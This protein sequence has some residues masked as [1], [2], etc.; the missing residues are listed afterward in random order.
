M[1]QQCAAN[2][3]L[4]GTRIDVILIRPSIP[5]G[6][7]PFAHLFS[8]LVLWSLLFRNDF[9]SL[10]SWKQRWMALVREVHSSL[11]SIG[12]I[13]YK[14]LYCLLSGP[15]V[16][17]LLLSTDCVVKY[18]ILVLVNSSLSTIFHPFPFV[19][20]RN[21][22]HWIRKAKHNVVNC[23]YVTQASTVI[24]EPQLGFK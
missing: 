23:L 16:R 1:M 17:Y 15:F 22:S 6:W 5:N 11:P 20:H 3:C 10:L 18:T 4:R 12:Y 13:L 14:H 9:D 24:F 21:S 2:Y 19:N 8:L 7:Y